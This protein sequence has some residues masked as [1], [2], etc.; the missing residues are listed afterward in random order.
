MI[1]PSISNTRPTAASGTRTGAMSSAAGRIRPI[2]A[3]TS[4]VPMALTVPAPKSSTHP[5]PEVASFCLGRVSFMAPLARKTTASSPAMIHRAMFM[6]V[7]CRV[8]SDLGV[9]VGGGD[10]RCVRVARAG[11]GRSLRQ[12]ASRRCR[13]PTVAHPARRHRRRRRCG[14]RRPERQ[15][16]RSRPPRPGRTGHRRRPSPVTRDGR[17][18]C[19]PCAGPAT[20]LV[21]A[22]ARACVPR[23]G[24]ARGTAGAA[25]Q[26]VGR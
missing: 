5:R 1:A 17:R 20:L 12:V 10:R 13:S 19:G 8:V 22:R 4:R 2:A 16:R 9:E 3:R 15:G 7:S 14:R 26:A 23:T 6:R 25:R 24:R 11:R 18:P 21:P